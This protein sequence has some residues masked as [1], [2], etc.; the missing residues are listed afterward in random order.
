VLTIVGGGPGTEGSLTQAA[1]AALE[2]A[3]TI[4][5]EPEVRHALGGEEAWL[6]KVA[7]PFAWADVSSARQFADREAVWVVPET[8]ALYPPVREWTASLNPQEWAYLRIVS[9]VPAMT[10]QLDR[11]GMFLPGYRVT[12]ETADAV[13]LRWGESGWQGDI[14]RVSWADARPLDGRRVVLL[15][16][17]SRMI[18]V[19]RWL[20]N[21]GASVELYPVSRLTEPD[22]YQAVD[23][24][25]RRIARYDWIVFT[26]AEA[27]NRWFDRMRHVSVD[28]RQVR[29]RIAVVGPETAVRVRERGLIPELMPQAEY[30][31]EGLV[32]SFADIP[33]RGAMVLFP[34]GQLNRDILGDE[35]RGRG[36][37]VDDVVLYENQ[38]VPIALALHQAIRSE[39]LDALLF[40]ASSQTEYLVDQLPS[41]DRRHL[42]NLPI[43][44]IGPLTT[45]SLRHYGIEPVRE[46]SEPSLRLLA[47]EVR[48]Y[49]AGSSNRA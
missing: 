7:G 11:E 45:R 38:S 42:A 40:T 13:K 43:F 14:P 34:G 8:P 19:V 44:S 3:D 10:A 25:I 6:G 24:A 22:S 5:I 29:A 12:V 16:G 37:L 2:R 1:I 33:V 48:D 27:V 28:I 17:G 49:Y 9:G 36:A 15:R 18:R 39:S 46:A 41:D 32:R 23:Q 31:Q 21:W 30:S 26:S 4:F 47:E 35:L 20:E